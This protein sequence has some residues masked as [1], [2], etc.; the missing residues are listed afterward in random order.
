VADTLGALAGEGEQ[1]AR[2]RETLRVFLG[3]GGSYTAAA[4]QLSMHKNSVQYRVHKAEELLGRPVADNRLDVELALSLC[5]WVGG[6]VLGA[7][8]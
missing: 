7:A 3:C 2:L 1:V 4:G 8:S 6:V 5:R